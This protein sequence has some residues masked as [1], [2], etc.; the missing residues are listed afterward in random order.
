MFKRNSSNAH[1]RIRQYTY[2]YM[3]V[4]YREVCGFCLQTA[5][6]VQFWKS[7]G[8][9]PNHAWYIHSFP[10]LHCKK[11]FLNFGPK[12]LITILSSFFFLNRILNPKNVNLPLMTNLHPKCSKKIHFICIHF[13]VSIFAR[14][15]F[16]A[17]V[18]EARAARLHFRNRIFPPF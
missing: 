15:L 16:Q 6:L 8:W 1:T 13:T 9:S 12:L 17:L 11:S 10:R 3:Y 14:T 18:T 7:V 5:S 2:E 4:L